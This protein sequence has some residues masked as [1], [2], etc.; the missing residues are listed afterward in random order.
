MSVLLGT[1]CPYSRAVNTA[2]GHT[3]VI[4]DTRE[5]G[6]SRSAG[7]IVTD[8]VNYFLAGRVSNMTPV[9]T[10]R[11]H[12]WCAPALCRTGAVETRAL[13]PISHHRV[14]YFRGIFE[15]PLLVYRPTA[16]ARPVTS[17]P[18]SIRL[19][20]GHCVKTLLLLRVRCCCRCR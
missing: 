16:N 11:E 13:V 12:G 1:H 5:H 10:A 2:R 18:R 17:A 8:V 3:S 9:Y 14:L 15:A 6:P 19:T 4:L 7:A 20:V